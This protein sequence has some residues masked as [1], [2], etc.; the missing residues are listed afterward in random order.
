MTYTSRS[1]GNMTGTAELGIR[2]HRRNCALLVGVSAFAYPALSPA[3]NHTTKIRL[4]TDAGLGTVVTLEEDL[5]LDAT[6]NVAR[7]DGSWRF[8]ERHRLNVSIFD[9]SQD[10]KRT[11][12]RELIIDGEEFSI[13]EAVATDWK[14]RLYELGYSYSLV[15]GERTE[16]WI[17]AG[18]FLQD[19]ALTVEETGSGSDHASEDIVVPLPKFGTSVAHAFS[20]RW[21][22]RIGIDIFKLSISDYAASL[23]DLRTTLDYRFTDSFSVG[24]G[25]HLIDVTVDIDRSGWRGRF[26]WRTTGIML[27]GRLLW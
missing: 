26:D 10:G 14:M 4:D 11:L 22:G 13:G 15:R 12:D 6:T 27:Y 21:V 1:D 25:W 24:A 8:A 16:W 19:T 23:V 7:I 17:N 20:N 5:G 9:L 2:R 3:T 18:I